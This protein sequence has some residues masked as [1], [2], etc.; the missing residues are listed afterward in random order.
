[1]SFKPADFYRR[2][3]CALLLLCLSGC[4]NEGKNVLQ[5]GSATIGQ[6]LIDLKQAL[7]EGAMTEAE[8]VKAKAGILAFAE[9]TSQMMD[10]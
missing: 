1:M 7:D 3:C 5:L 4:F 6:Q 10:Q 2:V 9:A 8:Y